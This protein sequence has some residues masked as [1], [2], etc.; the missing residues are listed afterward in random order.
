MRGAELRDRGVSMVDHST[1]DDWKS[2]CDAVIAAMAASGSEFTAEDVR[3]FAGNPPKPNA[4]GARFLA[5]RRRGLIRRVGVTN[6]TRSTRHAC[7]LMVY[8]GAGQ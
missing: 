2:A 3:E 1:P 5:A 7:A 6:A 4:M 8:R